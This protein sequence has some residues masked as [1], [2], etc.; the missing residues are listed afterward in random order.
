V[1]RLINLCKQ[2]VKDRFNLELE[3][4]IIVM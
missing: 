3:E 4:E 2:K 1:V